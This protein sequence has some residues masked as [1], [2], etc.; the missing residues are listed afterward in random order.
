MSDT[1]TFK[2]PGMT[3][4]HCESSVSTEVGR[5]P[6]VTGV[7]VD[8]DTKLVQVHGTGVD[9]AAVVAAI[10]EAGFDVE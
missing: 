5:V 9:H 2:A 6:G 10:D 3:C 8:L 7:D 1:L 4:G